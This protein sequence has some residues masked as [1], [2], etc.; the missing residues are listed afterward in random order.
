MKPVYP[1]IMPFHSY[2]FAFISGLTIAILTS[3]QPEL[4]RDYSNDYAFTHVNILPMNQEGVLEDYHVWIQE[5]TIYKIA[6][7]DELT[8]PEDVIE[9]EGKGK[10]LIPGLAEMHAHIPVPR[11]ERDSLVYE[12]L[13]L[14]VANGI[15]T[16]R[17]MLGDPFHLELRGTSING[18]SCP[19]T[20]TADSL[21]RAHKKAGYDFLKLHPGL[22]KEVFDEIVATAKEVDIPYAGH[23]SLDVGIRHALKNDYASIDHVDGY[24]EGLVPDDSGLP[25]D[26][27]GFFGFAFTDVADRSMIE[28]LAA[29][30]V[31]Q[32]VAVVPTQSMI[33]RWTSPQAADSMI[34]QPEMSYM[35]PNTLKGW[36]EAHIGLQN[37]GYYSPKRYQRFI[38]LRRDIIQA[39]HNKGA[40]LMLGSDAPQVYNVPG[41]SIHHE[42]EAIHQSGLSTYETLQTGTLN[43]AIY[44]DQQGVFGT[45]EQGASAD[46]ILLPSNP[47]DDLKILRRHEGVMVRGTWLPRS[48]IERQLDIIAEGYK[49]L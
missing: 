40:L 11:G 39:L 37:T 43:P 6:P 32:G 36:K 45:V 42:L 10:Y 35:H 48:M 44:F 9:I 38:Q 12:T 28:E 14:Y 46:L 25:N 21:V 26:A 30:T 15:T 24:V 7:A 27:N 31:E 16:I 33:E 2:L 41:F 20:A 5:D 3:C 4:D 19:D 23:V 49:E 1:I 34:S 8:L 47:L 29:L 22:K 18:N 13:F 17:G